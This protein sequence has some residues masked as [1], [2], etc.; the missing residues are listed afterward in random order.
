MTQD[1]ARHQAVVAPSRCFD[2]WSLL[3]AVTVGALLVLVGVPLLFILL[4]ALFPHLG[5]GSLAEP[6][7]ALLPS[8]LDRSVA[9][10]ARALEASRLADPDFAA[11]TAAL[12][13]IDA[14]LADGPDPE[15]D[16]M[17]GVLQ[18]L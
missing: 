15:L 3:R 5:S 4:L 6:F 14:A 2:P 13:R 8:L 7:S 16:Q 17:Q 1:A 18:A 9:A 11:I 10:Y 12:A